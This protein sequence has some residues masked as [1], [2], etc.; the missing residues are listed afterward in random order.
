[1][2]RSSFQFSNFKSTYFCRMF[3][4]VQPNNA[5]PY[6]RKNSWKRMRHLHSWVSCGDVPQQPFL[7][8]VTKWK[9]LSSLSFCSRWKARF[10]FTRCFLSFS[11]F[12][13]IWEKVDIRWYEHGEQVEYRQKKTYFFN[14]T[15]S[16]G[17]EGDMLTLPNVPMIVSARWVTTYYWRQGTKGREKE[18]RIKKCIN[19]LAR[20]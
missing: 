12:S 15:A 6:S 14:P 11:V 19:A 18:T 2:F 1:M 20:K 3:S 8:F 9:N 5:A 16:I 4:Y 17:T 13:E 7:T 10:I